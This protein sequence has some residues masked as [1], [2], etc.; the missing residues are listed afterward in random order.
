MK[1]LLM[2]YKSTLK[3]TK[4][5]L[6][7]TKHWLNIANKKMKYDQIE[8]LKH[9]AEIY[10]AE[11][12]DIEFIIKWIRIGGQPNRTRGIE[13]R[14]AY[15]RE[16]PVDPYW[17]QLKSDNVQETFITDEYDDVDI[18][19]EKLIKKIISPL[20]KKEKEIFTMAANH[21]SIRQISNMTGIPRST[22]YDTLKN[23][24]KKIEEKGW[25]RP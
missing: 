3:N 25:F 19:Q 4:E 13:N 12:R 1:Q 7:Y 21:M 20:S 10:R 15:D 22:V 24:R 2:Q 5:L 17:I 11:I 23:S 18:D 14:A 9:D 16:I 8:I 6:R